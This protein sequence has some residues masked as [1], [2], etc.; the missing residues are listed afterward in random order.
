MRSP[1]ELHAAYT[2][3]LASHR[4]K[5][6]PLGKAFVSI[7]VSFR[8]NFLIEVFLANI[9]SVAYLSRSA[10]LLRFPFRSTIFIKNLCL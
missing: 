1:K 2:K 6:Y 4:P 8:K 5:V 9:R 3:A 7:S 10:N